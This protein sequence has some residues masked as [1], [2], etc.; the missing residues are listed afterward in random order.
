LTYEPARDEAGEVVGVSVAIVDVTP[1]KHAEAAKLESEAHFRHMIELLPQIPWIIDAEGR[2]L[3]VSQRWLEITGSTGDDWRGFGWLKSLHPNDVKPT[4]EALE[5]VFRTL[6]PV[7]VVYRVRK[8]ERHA[9]VRMRSRGAPRIDEDGKVVC[10]YGSME[11][12]A[13]AMDGSDAGQVGGQDAGQV[14]GQD[15]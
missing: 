9:W 12:L 2:A 6:E 8:S 14:G 11:V 5:V 13:E 1:I 7:D 3:D 10:W 4:M 15:A